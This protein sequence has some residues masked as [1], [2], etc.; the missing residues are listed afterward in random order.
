MST[1]AYA[2]L[3]A[4]V[5]GLTARKQRPA[6]QI[7]VLA[8]DPAWW[9]AVSRLTRL[10]VPYAVTAPRVSVRQA[11]SKTPGADGT[12]TTLARINTAT[13][14]RSDLQLWT[15]A[16]FGSMGPPTGMDTAW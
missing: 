5:D 6:E 11:R 1:F 14:A 2:D 7:G 3:I 16:S 10:L 12:K 4:T 9:P 15:P 13:G 8:S